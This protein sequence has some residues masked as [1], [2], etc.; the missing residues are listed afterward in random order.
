[1][2]SYASVE[3]GQFVQRSAGPADAVT[4]LVVEGVTVKNVDDAVGVAVA[5]YVG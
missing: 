4:D 3:A 1:M 2:P 5:E